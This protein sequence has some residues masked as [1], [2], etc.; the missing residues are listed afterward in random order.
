ME[1]QQL[2]LLDLLEEL[3]NEIE[4]DSELANVI[5]DED[6]PYLRENLLIESVKAAFGES[7]GGRKRK[8]S[9]DAWEWILS[10]DCGLPFSFDQCCL[11][12]GV[13][14]EKMLD[15]LRFYKR[16]LLS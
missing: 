9:D 8:P 6:L 13:D 4:F 3:K 7:R 16:R 14:P 10:D 1:Q 2:S 5:G 15:W 11:A 12:C